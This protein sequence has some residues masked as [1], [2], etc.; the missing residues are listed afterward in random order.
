MKVQQNSLYTHLFLDKSKG[1]YKTLKLSLPNLSLDISSLK[2]KIQE[3]IDDLNKVIFNSKKRLKKVRQSINYNMY[4]KQSI[5][6][7]SLIHVESAVS[8]MIKMIYIV[9]LK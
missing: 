9:R 2:L 6:K 1:I 7:E 4:P 8:S 3:L 5:L